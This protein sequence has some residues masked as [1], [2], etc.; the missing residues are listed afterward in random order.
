MVWAGN[1]FP[2]G[3]SCCKTARGPRSRL[4]ENGR[5]VRLQ[6]ASDEAAISDAMTVVPLAP[7][8]NEGMFASF[9]SVLVGPDG[10]LAHVRPV[11]DARR[12]ERAAA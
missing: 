7:G 9:T 12:A 10:Y 3:N 1:A 5:R 11:A 4:L 2:T 8:A 6:L